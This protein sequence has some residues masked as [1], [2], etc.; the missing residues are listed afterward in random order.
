MRSRN[1]PVWL[2]PALML[3]GALLALAVGGIFD[4][5]TMDMEQAQYC[6]MVHDFKRSDGAIGWPD[7]AESY[8]KECTAD[9]KVRRD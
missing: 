9:G 6:L 3:L 8:D 7:Y 4:K 1:L 5:Q 2:Y